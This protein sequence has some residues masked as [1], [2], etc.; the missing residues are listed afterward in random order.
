MCLFPW[1]LTP[2]LVF[3][4]KLAQF[5]VFSMKNFFHR[6][7]SL[8]PYCS[9][10]DEKL[11]IL[12]HGILRAEAFTLRFLTLLLDA[13]PKA[14]NHPLDSSLCKINVV[15]FHHGLNL[16]T[17]HFGF[18]VTAGGWN[19][20]WTIAVPP[21]CQSSWESTLNKFHVSEIWFLYLHRHC[22][23]HYPR[24]VKIPQNW[25]LLQKVN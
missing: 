8:F 14:A 10:T 23:Y 19:L 15:A 3:S 11:F 17:G 24:A 2:A 25:S 4:L 21:S 22:H 18:K 9:E 16:I 12:M 1:M 7:L 20:H 5:L 6:F 13:V